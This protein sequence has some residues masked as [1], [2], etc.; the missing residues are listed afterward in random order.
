VQLD[1]GAATFP[2]LTS[3][4][5]GD[6][7]IAATYAGDDS[8]TGGTDS[9]S[10]HVTKADTLTTVMASP[11]PSAE[12]QNVTITATVAPVAPGSGSPTGTVSFTSDGDPIG[13]GTLH[14]VSGGG[15]QAT[16]LIADLAPG[17]HTIRA[18]YGGDDAFT[19]SQSDGFSQ[20][21][22]AGI[23]RVA[24]T[25]T[26]TSSTNPSTYGELITFRAQVAA[27]GSGG[28]GGPGGS[29]AT[30]TGTVQFSVDG[31]DFGDPVPV[32]ADGVA[33]SASL[34]SPDPG[35]HTVIAAYTPDAGW[36]GSG[37]TITQT[38]RDA[39]VAV[40][41][42]SSQQHSGYGQGVTFTASVQSQQVGTGRPTG[43]VQFSVDGSELGDAVA[44]HDG[45]ATSPQISDLAPGAHTV[46]ALYSG[47]VDFAAQSD[48]LTQQ[49]DKI[50]TTATITA[51]PASSTYG[52]TV[53]LAAKVTPATTAFGL[54]TGTV[55]FV[56]GATTLGTVALAASGSAST[57]T[58]TL[59]GLPAGAH[60]I[61]AVYAGTGLFAGDTSAAAAVSVAKRATSTS[62]V[63]A[64]VSLSPLG[65][66]LGQLKATVTSSLGP[67][68][69]V[70]VTFSI[71]S[72]TAC[73]VTTDSSGVAI[74]SAG[75]YLVQLVT[76]NGYTASFAGTDDFV[77]SSA[78]A[79]I[80]K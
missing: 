57:A 13:A 78:K 6:H 32:G 44:L 64:V 66:P 56:D 49:V 19:T 40:H 54:P 15:S 33:E 11:S 74:C 62:A 30:P 2:T 10:Q 70:P 72:T 53:T 48:T 50:G 77:G 31:A 5:A 28:S 67:V 14:A 65:L 22:V 42:T 68:A 80:L 71:G 36:S 60:T 43:F 35:D 17:T 4:L 63:G 59:T 61:K 26:L 69:G 52:D 29:D 24:T 25:T 34:A 58:L 18:G 45:S 20:T 37:D 75:K 39:S 8:F 73:T 55:S 47:D 51:T 23:A 16:L 12:D 46:T 9:F 76:S 38:V 21:V 1:G 3:L 41:L 27:D 7:T 79:G